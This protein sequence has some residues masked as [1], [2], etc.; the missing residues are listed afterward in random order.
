[1]NCPVHKTE[2]LVE[3]KSRC[4]KCLGA[5]REYQKRRREKLK[6]DGK[7]VGTVGRSKCPNQARV[8][9]TMCQECADTFNKY[10][11]ERLKVRKEQASA[12]GSAS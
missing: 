3:G 1:M 12:S 9:K 4:E 7:C 11:L 8:G 10:Q 2:P 6:A 5:M